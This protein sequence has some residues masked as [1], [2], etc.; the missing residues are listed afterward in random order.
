[1][2]KPFVCIETFPLTTSSNNGLSHFR[3]RAYQCAEGGDIFVQQKFRKHKIFTK[4]LG[5]VCICLFDERQLCKA[6][7]ILERER[8]RSWC[9]KLFLISP[10]FTQPPTVCSIWISSC[11]GILTQR[12]NFETWYL[13]LTPSTTAWMTD[14]MTDL[15]TNSMTDQNC[16]IRAVLSFTVIKFIINQI[17]KI[18]VYE[19][20]KLIYHK[21]I[22]RRNQNP[23]WKHN[24]SDMKTQFIQYENTVYPIWKH[25]L[26]DM[27]TWK[28][29]LSDMK[30]QFIW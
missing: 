17:K 5:T 9:W 20:A 1:M 8:L 11:P 25:S 12:V 28:H 2:R 10:V 18:M 13:W 7:V 30:T 21:S 19:K 24:L 26:S 27:K 14:I 15:I 6:G 3:M 23:I 29:S 16:D 22:H 4:K